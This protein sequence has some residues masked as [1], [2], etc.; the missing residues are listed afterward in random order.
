M[1]PQ[2]N[3][4]HILLIN[5]WIHD[6]AAYDFWAKPMGLLILGAVLREHGCIIS[7]IDCLD[8]FHPEDSQKNLY[9]RNG[10][11]PY[12]KTIIPKPR[13][14]ED[15]PRNYSR[16]GIKPEWLKK[17]LTAVPKP[18]LILVTSLMTYW[19][20][21]VQE[22]ISIIKQILPDVPV[23]LGGI[24][25][26][27][28]YEHAVKN[29]GADHV[30]SGSGVKEILNIVSAYTGFL[31]D[32]KFD[33]DNMNTWPL[34][35]LDLQNKTAYV[36]IMTSKG[37]PFNCSYC[38]SNY[39]DPGW[40]VRSPENIVKEIFF[41]HEKYGV[42]D[43][44]FY[45]DALLINPE[46]RIVPVMEQ[47]IDSG[48]NLRFHTPN[49]V[50]IREINKKIAVLMFKSGF[51][52]IRLG[53][54][55]TVFEKRNSLDRKVTE[56]EFKMAA[57]YLLDAGFE[58]KQAGAYLLAGLPG[59]TYEAV[60]ESV[61]IVKQNN[62]TPVPAYYT[63]I[64]HTS[65]W[66]KAVECSRYNIEADPVFTNNAIFPCWNNGFSWETITKLKNLIQSE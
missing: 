30:F 14:L 5:P 19:Y 35:A 55:T 13:G 64:P 23:V 22:S 12:L 39:L 32:C 25:A 18:D 58:K 24:Y 57:E 42:K 34:P 65:M 15:I 16:Y 28:C 27:L 2:K 45:D 56:T 54:E 10:R 50:H 37:C 9:A 8:R 7:Y 61:K 38:A 6:F 53:L 44:I 62:I 3:N 66:K 33:P 17:D 47:I 41:W 43:Y 1:L 21:G 4:P 46:K 20:P 48:I 40:M 59:Q 60:E 51:K 63:P 36:P 31:P 26:A 52:T 49:A 11:G 29:S